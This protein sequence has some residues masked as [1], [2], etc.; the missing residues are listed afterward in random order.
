MESRHF[1]LR[2]TPATYS[3]SSRQQCR[4]FVI[5]VDNVKSGA[6]HSGKSVL[7]IM[8]IQQ[9]CEDGFGKTKSAILA[10]SPNKRT[11]RV[12]EQRNRIID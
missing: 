5:V 9:N 1:P 10:G 12:S 3:I 2:T 7:F 6:T 11:E 4:Y 8:L